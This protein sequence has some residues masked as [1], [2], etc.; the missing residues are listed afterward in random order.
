MPQDTAQPPRRCLYIEA[1]P[2]KDNSASKAAA[3][4]F[5]CELQRE[6]T[7]LAIDKL[8]LWDAGLPEFNGAVIAAKYAKLAGRTMTAEEDEAWQRIG[9]MADRL[10]SADAVVV[11]TPM[12]NF[13]IPY[14]LK[15]WIDL[16]TQP[17]LT[18]SFDPVTGYAPLLLPK[19]ALIILSSAGDYSAGPSRGR[20]DL[21]SPYLK[22]AFKFIGLTDT[23]IILVGPTIGPAEQVTAART[24]ARERLIALA[25]GF[26]ERAI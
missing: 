12:W 24:A 11:A 4:A 19:P 16:V 8:D 18:F 13:G 14:K 3:M 7:G 1:S 17:G 5:L 10:R 20:P 15:H 2:R 23:R 26:M 6:Q 9:Q 21:V 22:E 25:A